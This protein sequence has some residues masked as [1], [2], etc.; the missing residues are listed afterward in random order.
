MGSW[1]IVVETPTTFTNELDLKVANSLSI[2]VC[3]YVSK[4]NKKKNMSL[5]LHPQPFIYLKK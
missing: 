3:Y 4:T 5:K 2:W 1:R